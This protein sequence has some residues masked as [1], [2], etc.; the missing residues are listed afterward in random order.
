MAG[1]GISGSEPL[2]SAAKELISLSEKCFAIFY[3]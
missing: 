2:C 1:F 3:N